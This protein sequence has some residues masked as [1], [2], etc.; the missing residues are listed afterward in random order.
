MKNLK[1]NKF[2]IM[3]FLL[4][5]LILTSTVGKAESVLKVSTPPDPNSLPLLLLYA[6]QDEWLEET[7]IEIQM[8]PSGDPG[9][10][11]ALIHS[12]KA[13][14]V[15]FS[16]FSGAKFFTE[17]EK[18]LR[19][20]GTHVWKGVYLLAREDINAW[21][22]IDGKR[23]LAIPGNNTPPHILAKKSLLKHDAKVDFSGMGGGAAL[24]TALSKENSQVQAVALPEPMVSRIL[25]KQKEENWPVKYKIFADPQK[26]L[27][28]ETGKLPL[29]SLFL[30]D[31][32][33][34]ETKKEEI[35][36]FIKGFN[37]AIKQINTSNPEKTVEFLVPTWKEVFNQK[38]PPQL[39]KTV[40]DSDRLE[41]DFKP[42]PQIR[43]T[44][45]SFWKKYFDLKV[46]NKFFCENL[47]E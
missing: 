28:P 1:N 31:D 15:L 41:L 11:R 46:S 32:S 27:N 44:N 24:W 6:N 42:A 21:E 4:A 45:K 29:G 12:K 22:K 23:G 30:T 33:L 3:F 18:D 38:L 13:D 10:T 35:N 37:K 40:L 20:L 26:E 25:L 9:A 17:G 19:L 16:S 39:F 34:A 43:E 7:K 5:I 8:S 47:Y 2:F 36:D 14:L